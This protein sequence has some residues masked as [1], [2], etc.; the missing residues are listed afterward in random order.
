MKT[1]A[2]TL[3]ALLG[4]TALTVGAAFADL[5]SLNTPLALVIAAT[6][7]AL[8]ILFFMHVRRSGPLVRV[9]IASGFYWL[10]ILLVLTLSDYW[11]R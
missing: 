8:V 9:V 5:G 6:K 4:L 11:F 7:G 10:G 3:L 1:Y 2:N